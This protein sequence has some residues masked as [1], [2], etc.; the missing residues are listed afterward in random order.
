MKNLK[1]N[2]RVLHK[3]NRLILLIAKPETEFDFFWKKIIKTL[4]SL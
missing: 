4:E 3:Q 2:H 1:K